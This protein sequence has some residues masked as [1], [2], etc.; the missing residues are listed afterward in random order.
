LKKHLPSVLLYSSACLFPFGTALSA[1]GQNP[2]GVTDKTI[3]I[4]SCSALDGPSHSL[5]VETVAGANTYF[6]LTNDEGG[7]NG[8]KLKLVAYDDSYDPAKTQVCFDHLL[9]DKVSPWD[10][11]WAHRRPCRSPRATRYR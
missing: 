1:R 10:S 4:G 5:G 6:S 9:T 11:S 8:R 2:P 3:V 7:V